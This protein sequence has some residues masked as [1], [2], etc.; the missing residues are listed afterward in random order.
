MRW[1]GNNR[2]SWSNSSWF[3]AVVSLTLAHALYSYEGQRHRKRG[4]PVWRALDV[5]GPMVGHNDFT[6]D[7]QPQA[8]PLRARTI[9]S[10]CTTEWGLQQRVE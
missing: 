3:L 1:C 4:A 5:D 2:K 10:Y 9:S 8:C 6:H 7:I